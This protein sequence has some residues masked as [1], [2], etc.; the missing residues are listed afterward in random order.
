MQK[1]ILIMESSNT[2]FCSSKFPLAREGISLKSMDF[3]QA[4]SNKFASRGIDIRIILMA[5]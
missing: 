2:W 5:S 1:L 3:G 4:P